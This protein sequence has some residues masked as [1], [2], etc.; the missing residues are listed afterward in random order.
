M[1]IEVVRNML[2]AYPDK[3]LADYLMDGLI[4]GFDI[5]VDITLV[6]EKVCKNNE[7]AISQPQ[8]VSEL[9]RKEV[10]KV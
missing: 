6:T 3:R 7:S 10:D 2:Q 8:V 5:G 1:K 9:I 4:E